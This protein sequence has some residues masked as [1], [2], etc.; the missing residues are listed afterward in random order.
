MYSRDNLLS[1]ATKSFCMDMCSKFE[2]CYSLREAQLMWLKSQ[3]K[4]S[5]ALVVTESNNLFSC[6]TLLFNILFFLF[7][8]KS[9]VGIHKSCP[10]VKY[11]QSTPII[12]DH[13]FARTGVR[14]LSH[15]FTFCDKL[16]VSIHTSNSSNILTNDNFRHTI[17]ENQRSVGYEILYI[18]NVLELL[19]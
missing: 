3:T 4:G 14:Q 10:Q 7:S 12:N 17:Q 13:C 11:N 6:S 8:K 1:V 2:G 5:Q 15:D 19:L 18:I 16:G 9:V